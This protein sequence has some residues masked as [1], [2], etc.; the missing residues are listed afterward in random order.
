MRRVERNPNPPTGPLSRRSFL[1]CAATAGA[2]AMLPLTDWPRISFGAENAKVVGGL[3]DLAIAKGGTPAA[4]CLA[5]V[6]ALGGFSRFVK[7]GNVVFVKPNPVARARPEQGIHT[8]PDVVEAVVRGCL[9]AGARKVI[10]GSNDSMRDMRFNGTARAVEAAGG[11]LKDYEK[12]EA[13]REI[14]VPRGRILR[15]ERIIADLIDADVF[16]NL[17]LAKHHAET[18]VTLTMKNLMGVNWD[19]M[20]FHLT[21]IHQC[22]AELASAIPHHLILMDANHVLLTNGPVGP[23]E[24]KAAGQVFAGTDPVAIDTLAAN[25]FFRGADS[26]RCIRAAYDLG[27]GEMDLSRLRVQEV[28]A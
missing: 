15:R 13:F 11:E 25:T 8:H 18:G 10:V 7:P 28:N 22:I 26:Y 20:N 3:P 14:L 5:A 19:R 2:A 16:I 6:N 17:P 1:K 12:P 21:D 4:N 9:A 24:V 27:V 23:G